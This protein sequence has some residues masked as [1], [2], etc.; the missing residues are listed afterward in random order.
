M[1]VCRG[2]VRVC[3]QGVYVRECVYRGSVLRGCVREFV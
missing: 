1:S 2:C 3:K